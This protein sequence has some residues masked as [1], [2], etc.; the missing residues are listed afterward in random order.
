MK[1]LRHLAYSLFFLIVIA[2]SALSADKVKNWRVSRIHF[3]GNEEISDYRLKKVMLT[4]TTS[5]FSRK[6]FYQAVFVED[7]NSVIRYYQ[8]QGYLE[9]GI[10]DTVVTRNSDTHKIDLEITLDEGN[11]TMVEGIGIFGNVVFPDSVLQMHIILNKD[12]PYRQKRVADATVAMLIEYANA[13]FLNADIQPDVRVNSETHLALVDFHITE[14]TQF[15]IAQINHLGND[16]TRPNVV[17]RELSFEPG[18]I[19]KRSALLKSQRQLYLTGLFQSVFIRPVPPSTGDSTEKDIAIEL[20]END[21]IELTASVGYGTFEKAR[22]KLG[23]YFNNLYGTGRKFGITPRISFVYRG[24]EASYSEPWTFGTRWRT[25]INAWV[26]YA[27]EPGYHILRQGGRISVGRSLGRYTSLTIT[28]RNELS[29]LSHVEVSPL[30]ENLDGFV[31]SLKVSP[32]FDSRDNMFNTRRGI[33]LEWSN[34]LA[35]SFLGGDDT[36]LRS[37]WRGKWFYS[38]RSNTVFGT[39]LEVGWM[40]HLGGSDEIPLNER[41]YTGGPNS[42]RAIGY[43]LAGPLDEDGTPLGGQFKLVWNAVEI[44]QSIYKMIGAAAF[45]DVG[46]VWWQ[47]RDFQLREMRLAPGFGLRINTPIGIVRGDVGF[48]VDARSG[49]DKVQFF[50]NVGQT[51]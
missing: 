3:E 40:D 2:G 19:V 16:R 23:I 28:F 51:F 38:L 20:K 45:L 1:T 50:F 27:E 10:V 49:E 26:D 9:A 25:D 37:I 39:A 6:K 29:K 8:N 21:A 13:G 4:R 44:R 7:L 35:G 33:Y 43:Q 32:V 11:R 48:N 18:D 22:A 24:V 14:G 30:P 47:I 34:E 31:R 5:L 46:N 12:D 42:L 17:D 36:F 41:F 15:H